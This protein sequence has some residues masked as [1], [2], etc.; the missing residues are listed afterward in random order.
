[1]VQHS[2]QPLV[3]ARTVVVVVFFLPVAKHCQGTFFFSLN[4]F[5]IHLDAN[6]VCPSVKNLTLSTCLLSFVCDFLNIEKVHNILIFAKFPSYSV[7]DM[8]G[9]GYFLGI[10]TLKQTLTLVILPCEILSKS[11][12]IY[13]NRMLQ[14][15]KTEQFQCIYLL[16]CLPF[17][18]KM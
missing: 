8:L 12:L 5:T 2:P 15:R 17:V 14:T 9:G 13:Q 16:N 3:S 18:S 7:G 6:Y 10:S 4:L 1:M 11:D